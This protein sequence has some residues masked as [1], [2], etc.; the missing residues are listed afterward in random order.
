MAAVIKNLIDIQVRRLRETLLDAVK[1]F[2]YIVVAFGIVPLF[3]KFIDSIAINHNRTG[4]RHALRDIGKL[5]DRY[6]AVQN[7]AGNTG[8]GTQQDFGHNH[9]DDHFAQKRTSNKVVRSSFFVLV[10]MRIKQEY[11]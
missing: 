8:E 9:H 3:Y 10:Y 2:L 6:L 11:A 5:A 7:K 1:L 4:L